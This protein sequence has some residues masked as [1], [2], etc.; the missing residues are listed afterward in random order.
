MTDQ[1]RYI[2]TSGKLTESEL[3]E[4]KLEAEPDGTPISGLSS[5]TTDVCAGVQMLTLDVLSDPS[6]DVSVDTPS[7]VNSLSHSTALVRKV[8]VARGEKPVVLMMQEDQSPTWEMDPLISQ[9]LFCLETAHLWMSFWI[10]FSAELPKNHHPLV[11][12]WTVI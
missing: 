7:Y 4:I 10:Q 8:P 6:A 1:K 11:T 9:S 5:V 12:L 2:L 3:E